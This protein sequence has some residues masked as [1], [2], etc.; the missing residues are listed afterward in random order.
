[1]ATRNS[2][3]TGRGRGWGVG[4]E[5][6]DRR[7]PGRARED[8]LASNGKQKLSWKPLDNED[9][10]RNEKEGE[11]CLDY[12]HCNKFVK[13]NGIMCENC[14][15]WFHSE[16]VDMSNAHYKMF[17][18]KEYI[19]FCTTCKQGFKKKMRDL[20][21]ENKILNE[22]NQT[23]KN[24]CAE[25]RQ[26]IQAMKG[27]IEEE[28]TKKVMDNLRLEVKDIVSEELKERYDKEKRKNN[29]VLYNIQEVEGESEEAN[30]EDDLI[31]CKTVLQQVRVEREVNVR[32][33]IR[34]GKKVQGKARPML[35][36]LGDESMK[37]NVMRNLKNLK[38]TQMQWVKK[39]SVTK[40][41]TLKEREES[42]R[43][44]EQLQEKRRQGEDGWFIKNDKLM[45][46]R[47]D[48]Q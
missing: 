24:E 7:G 23:L 17:R 20:E 14:E 6:E 16:C 42:K 26:T 44:W 22:E 48:Q 19:W 3:G 25:W 47:C 28:V 2:V 40:D 21:V 33:V 9:D 43:L 46:N 31:K 18:D 37:W 5:K 41:L 12:C 10:K 32:G 27:E 15:R 4:N 11:I 34:L 35:V 36:R 38:F 30:K 13:S 1:M 8:S 29:I 45:R 39:V